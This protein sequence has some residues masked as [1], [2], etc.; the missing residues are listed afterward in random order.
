MSATDDGIIGAEQAKAFSDAFV[1][2]L[3]IER[4][5]SQHTVKAYASDLA[6]FLDWLERAGASL[7]KADHRVM[8]RYLADLDSAR[9]ARATVNR[10][11]SA[12]K[13]FYRWLVMRGHLASNPTTVVSGP[14]RLR[15]LP[16]LV[17]HD[18]LERLLAVVSSDVPAAPETPTELRDRCLVELLYASGARVSE[19]A[20]LALRDVDYEQGQVRLLGKGSKERI[21]PLHAMALDLLKRYLKE[22]R[23]VFCLKAAARAG[24]AERPE[25]L[26][27]LFLTGSGRAM[28]ASAMRAALKRRLRTTGGDLALSPHALRHTFATDLLENGA[29]LRSVQELLG[30]ARLSTTQIYT[31]LSP[32][33]LKDAYQKAHP[34]A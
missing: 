23:P 17:S 32:A 7:D 9:Y 26:Q 18:E 28:S 3:T 8:R 11:L 30:H 1:A 6:Q 4:N 34:R 2:S 12:V 10:R 29:S 31:H 20:A 25:Q 27:T 19:V 21:V 14:K 16:S 24:G 22:A 5:F 33:H 15:T 13:S